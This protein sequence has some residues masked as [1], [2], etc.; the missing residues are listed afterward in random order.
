MRR[1]APAI[2]R[3]PQC[4][5]PS[6]I[7][8][9]VPG[10]ERDFRVLGTGIN[11]QCRSARAI[12]ARSKPGVFHGSIGGFIHWG[13]FHIDAFGWTSPFEA[14]GI[15]SSRA[16]ISRPAI[17]IHPDA[18]PGMEG[19]FS[20]GAFQPCAIFGIWKS[21]H[22]ASRGRTSTS[23]PSD[24]SSFAEDI[25]QAASCGSLSERN[26]FLRPITNQGNIV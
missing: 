19:L 21:L 14:G 7:R 11:R 16:R 4:G 1:G 24:A 20:H 22:E 9:T 13:A 5:N 2:L 8:R 15:E 26:R 18:R 6:G 12:F 17:D 23:R 10:I 25:S 3:F